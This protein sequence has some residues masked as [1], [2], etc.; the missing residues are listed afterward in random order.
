MTNCIRDSLV[1]SRR[2]AIAP[3]LGQSQLFLHHVPRHHFRLRVDPLH[4]SI[5]RTLVKLVAERGQF[6]HV[7]GFLLLQSLLHLQLLIAL[8]YAIVWQSGSTSATLPPKLRLERAS[9]ERDLVRAEIV[10]FFPLQGCPVSV[11]GHSLVLELKPAVTVVV[12]RFK[13]VDEHFEA[14]RF[15]MVLNWIWSTVK[16]SHQLR[17]ILIP[18]CRMLH[19][20]I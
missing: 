20:L 11:L 19:R 7:L 14:G 9:V 13:R 3:K 15:L 16:R 2:L 18:L 1:K 6:F 12:V 10:R 17:S 4:S 8:F 5:Q